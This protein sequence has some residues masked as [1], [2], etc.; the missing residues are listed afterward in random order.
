[1][2]KK[3]VPTGFF[4]RLMVVALMALGST[5]LV[6]AG[7]AEFHVA[8][9]GDDRGPGT[10]AAPFATIERAQVA[11]RT[12][13]AGDGAIVWLHAG[14]HRLARPLVFG[15]GDGGLPDAE[16]T[17]A[18]VPGQRVEISGARMLELNWTQAADGRWEAAV[19]AGLEFDQLFADG[20]KM[21]RARYPNFDPADGFFGGLSRDATDPARLQRYADPT[22][23]FVHGYHGLA[24]GS[25]HFQIREKSPDGRYVF[26]AGR[27]PRVVGGWQNKGRAQIAEAPFSPDQ[28]FVE[29]VAEELDAPKEWFL[30]RHLSRLAFIPPAG[31]DPRRMVFE[32]VVLPHLIE[33]RGTRDAPVRHLTFRGLE[34]RRAAY[35]FMQTDDVPSG[36]DWRIH[37]G[38]ALDFAG[39]E[40]CAVRDCLFDGIGGNGI[41]VGGYNQGIEVTGC[42]FTRI[43]ASAVLFDGDKSAV[44]SRW[45]HEWGWPAGEAGPRPLVNGQP[46]GPFMALLPAALLDHAVGDPLVD[47]LP[48]PK[49]ED[50][51]ARCLVRDCLMHG[52]GTVEKQVAGVFISKSRDIV[53]SHVTIHD[54]PRAAININDGTWGGHVVEWCDVFD[55][56]RESREHGAINAWGRDRYW[57]RMGGAFT[58]TPEQYGRMRDMARLDAVDVITL[59][60]NRVQCANGFDIDLD[61][62]ASHYDI[63]HNLCLQGG[64]KLREGFFRS[65]RYNIT[66]LFG[67]HV[68]YPDSHDVFTNNI[69]YGP[70]GYSP[71]GMTMARARD[72]ILDFNLF[73]H[74]AVPADLRQMGIDR[75]SL[76]ADPQFLDAPAGD[77]RVRD[78]S[79]AEQ[80]GFAN[81]P[82]D[83]F[84]VESAS[85]LARV[86]PWSGFTHG[87]SDA[88]KGDADLRLHIWLGATLRNL[89]NLGRESAVVGG[90]EL[91]DNRG[92]LIKAVLPES[93]AAQAGLSADDVIVEANGAAVDSVASLGSILR[94]ASGVTV[95]LKILTVH[96]YREVEVPAGSEPPAPVPVKG[97]T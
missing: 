84:G 7:I 90:M 58:A 19:P 25:L 32:A 70:E 12:R 64:I 51:P 68:W 43:G 63:H 71:R 18:A 56:C 42:E 14:V 73:A 3:D 87:A 86:T 44:R 95:R 62:G 23:M 2:Q 67:P 88:G 22:G 5:V 81:F 31:A 17:Y 66:P 16:V 34:F 46:A 69:V 26:E 24:W 61:D 11:V 50:Y 33:V 20:K 9:E 37:R 1:M 75:H 83:C 45:A 94:G 91:A 35:T 52:L 36:G 49:T 80:I 6:R 48:G 28:R 10:A 79:P 78:G 41:F 60:Y 77:Y 59:R 89:T 13:T 54:V 53:V 27:D 72:A 65:V 92:I 97:K 96:G 15:P 38:G 82:M 40:N 85:L 93:R 8:P 4:A 55:T 21:I 57:M 39:A 47:L 74:F 29:N 76:T 30:D